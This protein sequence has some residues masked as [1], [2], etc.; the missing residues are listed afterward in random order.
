MFPA[1]S[2]EPAAD[3]APADTSRADAIATVVVTLAYIVL[4][5]A[6]AITHQPWRDEAQ[7]WLWA[8]AL[9]TP[10]EFLI[11]P[12]EGHPPLW[13]WL[14][15]GLALI[16]DFN[17]ARYFTVGIAILNAVLL[18]RLLHGQVLLLTLLLFSLTLTQFW[19]HHFRPY[20]LVLLCLLTAMLLQRHGRPLLASWVM[21]LACG[22]HFFAGFLFGFWLILQW[23]RGIAWRSLLGPAA[24]GLLFGLSA[25]LSGLGNPAGTPDSTNLLQAFAYN[26]AWPLTW[27]G[28]RRWPAALLV[29][30]VLCYGLWHARFILVVLLVL[31]VSFAFGTAAVYGQSPWHAAFMMMLA[32]MA[33]VFAGPCARRWTLALLLAPQMI[34]GISASKSR[35]EQP[36]WDQPDLYAVI[37]ADAGPGFDPATQLVAWQDFN[38]STA[39]ASHGITYIS[40]NNGALLGPVDWRLRIEGRVDPVLSTTPT[41]FWLVCGHCA[42]AL[43]ASAAAGHAA[44]ELARI[45][46]PDD[47]LLVAYRI[48]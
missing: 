35:L 45:V 13:Y 4:Q 17:Q 41:P 40:G 8:G 37:R 25:L 30:A 36:V 15:R 26:L 29:I 12:G 47:G 14:L 6:L 5:L 23:H 3:P 2:P 11:I 42:P 34:A 24:L 39:A 46:N 1:A 20:G 33:F 9:A 19:G 27:P 16:L 31:T 48:D 10:L 32:L 44:T 38:L 43:A 7:A 28:L 22:F 21:A 18:A